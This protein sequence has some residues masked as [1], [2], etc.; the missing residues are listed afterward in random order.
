M[1]KLIILISDGPMGSTTLSSIIGNCKFLTFP[2]R[3]LGLNKYVSGEYSLDNPFFIK[4]VEECIN[5]LSK[6]SALRAL[7]F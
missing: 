1:K 6:K 7:F 5:S 2:L 3:H 4:R